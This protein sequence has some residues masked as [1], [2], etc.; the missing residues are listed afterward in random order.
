MIMV[1][2][3]MLLPWWS[4]HDM[5]TEAQDQ[6]DDMAMKATL[7]YDLS[8]MN[9]CY[10][11]LMMLWWQWLTSGDDTTEGYSDDQDR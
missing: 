3:E 2:D 4:N 11:D 1:G 10:D 7:S 9:F 6:G 5:I 8:V